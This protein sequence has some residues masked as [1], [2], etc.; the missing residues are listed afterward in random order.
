MLRTGQ[1]TSSEVETFIAAAYAYAHRI[2]QDGVAA[3]CVGAS[4][5][6]ACSV[7]TRQGDIEEARSY[8]WRAVECGESAD[9]RF[10]N[11]KSV[12]ANFLCCAFGIEIRTGNLEAARSSLNRASA[13]SDGSSHAEKEVRIAEAMLMV[14]DGHQAVGLARPRDL[15]DQGRIQRMSLV[16]ILVTIK[17][18]C[19]HA[20]KVELADVYSRELQAIWARSRKSA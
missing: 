12:V 5:Y 11:R 8:V 3:R 7:G 6:G 20:G 13:V 1:N 2:T 17:W 18:A 10:V 14:A 4:L 16:E 15:L 9:E 19:E